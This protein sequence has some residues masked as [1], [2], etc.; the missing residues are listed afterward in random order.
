MRIRWIVSVVQPRRERGLLSRQLSVKTGREHRL[1]RDSVS[2][3]TGNW[4]RIQL[5][6]AGVQIPATGETEPFA[7]LA[8]SSLPLRLSHLTNMSAPKA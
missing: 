4:R 1:R 3:V 7:R 5:S 2:S 8:V 6:A